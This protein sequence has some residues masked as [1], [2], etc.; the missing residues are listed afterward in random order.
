MPK[1]VW[2]HEKCCGNSSGFI[3]KVDLAMDPSLPGDKK[4]KRYP[5]GGNQLMR[6][7]ER[8]LFSHLVLKGI[9]QI[10]N[11]NRKYTS[12]SALIGEIWGEMGRFLPISP[13]TLKD[14]CGQIK[15][16]GQFLIG[17]IDRS[18]HEVDRLSSSRPSRSFPRISRHLSMEMSSLHVTKTCTMP[19]QV[20]HPGARV[21]R[22]HASEYCPSSYS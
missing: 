16:P 20:W 4:R 6:L 14:S 13:Q 22:P 19:P 2:A 17:S 18:A 3:V 8:L 9:Y 21:S 10:N 11:I 5:T 15:A 1:H 12:A 7:R